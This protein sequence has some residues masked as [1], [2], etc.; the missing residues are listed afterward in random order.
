MLYK[1]EG[2]YSINSIDWSPISLGTKL[3][4][5]DSEGNLIIIY[6]MGS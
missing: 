2:E 1:Y 3:A 4:G 6:K 5:C